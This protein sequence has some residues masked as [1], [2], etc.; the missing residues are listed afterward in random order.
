MPTLRSVRPFARPERV[1]DAGVHDLQRAA[2]LAREY[3]DRR[4]AGQEVFHHLPGHALGIGRDTFGDDAVV[5]RE[6][7]DGRRAQ[8]DVDALLHQAEL[9]GQLFQHPEAARRL[10]L[11][12]DR[13]VEACGED[14]VM[15]GNDVGQ[16]HGRDSIRK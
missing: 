16:F 4:A 13:G 7:D 6:H 15:D 11:V 12:V 5:A 1:V 14:R 3:I 9:D 8:C 2:V 10:G